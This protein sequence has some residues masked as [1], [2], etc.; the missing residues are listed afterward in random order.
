MSD[1]S[2]LPRLQLLTL[3]TASKEQD[4]M[5]HQKKKRRL[6]K[7]VLSNEA[8]FEET[9]ETLEDASVQTLLTYHE[10]ATVQNPSDMHLDTIMDRSKQAFS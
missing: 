1:G 9:Q 6:Q 7:L 2:L 4:I 10:T 8:S 5:G 3:T